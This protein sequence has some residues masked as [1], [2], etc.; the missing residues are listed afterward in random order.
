MA[1]GA[2]DEPPT[3]GSQSKWVCDP[4]PRAVEEKPVEDRDIV[5]RECER[6]YHHLHCT[7]VTLTR[8]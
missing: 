5:S 4:A 3:S 6:K 2:T 1:R 7:R 8:P